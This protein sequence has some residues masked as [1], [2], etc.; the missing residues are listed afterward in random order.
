MNSLSFVG[1]HSY[2]VINQTSS[3]G[4][5]RNKIDF[6]KPAN[7]IF[8]PVAGVLGRARYKNLTVAKLVQL[9]M[10]LS[11]PE[12]NMKCLLEIAE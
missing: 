10:F 3:C 4:M 12:Q 2:Q 7:G 8:F 5:K 1:Q 11:F 9:C 6:I